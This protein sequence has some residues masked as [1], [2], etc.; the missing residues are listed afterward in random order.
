MGRAGLRRRTGTGPAGGRKKRKRQSRYIVSGAC[1]VR[2]YNFPRFEDRHQRQSERS[3]IYTSSNSRGRVTTPIARGGKRQNCG[4][5]NCSLHRSSDGMVGFQTPRSERAVP[6]AR[7]WVQVADS[8]DD[9]V[10]KVRNT[11]VTAR[12]QGQAAKMVQETL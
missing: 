11:L 3:S 10:E 12:R 7:S 8:W 2:F 6:L 4:G 1:A 9:W 5:E